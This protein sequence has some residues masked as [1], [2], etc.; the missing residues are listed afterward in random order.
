MQEAAAAVKAAPQQRLKVANAGDPGTLAGLSAVL[1]SGD[2]QA[3]TAGTGDDIPAAAR[4]ALADMKDFLPYKSYRLLDAAWFVGGGDS[5]GQ[6]RGVDG[7]AYALRLK[8]VGV[9]QRLNRTTVSLSLELEDLSGST[10]AESRASEADRVL[11]ML[12]D[13]YLE[14]RRERAA[15]REK[16]LDTHPQAVAVDAKIRETTRQIEEAEASRSAA[17]RADSSIVYTSFTMNI[18]ETVVVGT[19]R[20]NGDKA[21]ILL[22]TAAGAQNTGRS[23]ATK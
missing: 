22:L 13:Q 11:K 17:M 5:N 3:S 6:L 4:K 1:V 15:L 2:L 19:S 12:Q 8:S 16:Y 20:V 14:L 9:G 10:R 7:R 21:L 18:G 23:P